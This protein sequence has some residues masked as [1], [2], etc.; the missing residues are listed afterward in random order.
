MKPINVYWAPFS[1]G[2]VEGVD[3]SYLYPDPKILYNEL[4]SG[5]TGEDNGS[6]FACPAVKSKF[7]KTLVFKNPFDCSYEYDYTENNKI[8]NPIGENF[9]S[10]TRERPNAITS[11]PIVEFPLRYALFSDE[12]LDAVFTPPFFSKPEY[13]QYGSV[14]PGEFNIGKW[15]RPYVVEMQL[16]SNKGNLEL[17]AN[18]PL[19]Y[20]ELRTERKIN[21]QRFNPTSTLQNY[22][23]SNVS[24]T[25][26]FGAGKTLDFRYNKFSNA[27]MRE[28]ILTEIKKNIVDETN[29][30][31]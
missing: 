29:T 13:T 19:F 14:M 4:L 16:W 7:K 20:V 21:L 18:E 17:K 28:K 30:S 24:L 22:S 23:R 15:F 27:S 11:G 12:P 6:F 9:L 10:V 8:F 26:I 1:Y 5:K 3:W 2:D 31:L 25:K